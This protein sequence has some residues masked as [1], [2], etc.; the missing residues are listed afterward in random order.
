[1]CSTPKQ[2]QLP[3]AWKNDS[4]SD[5]LGNA[6]SNILATFVHKR[7]R[8][9]HL[10]EID[11]AFYELVRNLSNPKDLLAAFFM[12]RS[13]SAFRAACGLAMSGQAAESFV[14]LRSCLEC[15]LYA[16][17]INKNP[18]LA[19]I[20][21]RRH[22]DAQ[23]LKRC[24]SEFAHTNVIKTLE[25]TDKKLHK[26]IQELYERTID[27]GAHPNE[28]AMTSNMQLIKTDDNNEFWSTYLHSDGLALD[29]ALKTAAQCGLGALLMFRSYISGA[30]YAVRGECDARTAAKGPLVHSLRDV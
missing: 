6:F 19:E 27:F 12:P 11:S 7:E 13:H 5:F 22:D 1:M 17:H 15:A 24:K 4:L 30:L 29:H 18:T 21:L 3:P 26:I 9:G 2:I 20:W 23:S 16:L 28:R 25:N 14:V 10:A 8:Y